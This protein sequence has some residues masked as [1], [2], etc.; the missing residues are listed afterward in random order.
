MIIVSHCCNA[1]RPRMRLLIIAFGLYPEKI[2]GME[3]FN[4]HLIKAYSRVFKVTVVTHS[5]SYQESGVNKVYF[6]PSNVVPNCII[7]PM[8]LILYILKH[9]NE[10]DIIHV[11][12]TTSRFTY[13]LPYIV[14][15]MVFG[16]PYIVVSHEGSLMPWT[17]RLISLVFFRCS[18]AIV[19]VSDDMCKEYKK[20]T[21]KKIDIIYPVIPFEKCH[22]EKGK[23][24][25]NFNL[26]MSDLILIFV[27]SLNQIKNPNILLEA[28]LTIP[29]SLIVSE[30]LRL[31]YV[32][33][34]P[35]L[36][37]LKAR[38]ER[39]SWRN[40]IYFMGKMPHEEM[41]K[42]YQLSDIYVQPSAYEGTSLSLMEALCNGLP[43]IANNVRGINSIIKDGTNGLLY[44]GSIR[45]LTSKLIDIIVDKEMR[46]RIA[47]QAKKTYESVFSYDGTI[48]QHI[49]IVNQVCK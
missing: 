39:S 23:L 16:I 42:F 41:P 32:G 30:G 9:H 29:D 27:G 17:P 45:D 25:K 40:R 48:S 5:D 20:R 6:K 13:W 31:I 7:I 28:F 15:K 26:L 10:I 18:S 35:N 12:Y 11:P 37:T 3:I 49:N 22:I 8:R 4:Y 44:D 38:S 36:P 46:Q 14:S 47:R 33:D 24:K 1:G 34:G 2:G 19:A 21:K 43:I